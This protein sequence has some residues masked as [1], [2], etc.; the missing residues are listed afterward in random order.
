[1][2]RA[3][4]LGLALVVAC[5]REK[6]P[7]PVAGAATRVDEDE[8]GS[9]T[10][11]V[12]GATIAS[13]T[14]EALFE[15]SAA[16]VID[17]DPG[18]YWLNP[19]RDFPQSIVIAL[20]ARARIDRV[21][22]RTA[23]SSYTANRVQFD[24]S[25]D[26]TTWQALTTATA[27][28]TADAQW[29]DVAP[30]EAEFLRVTV[31]DPRPSQ[32]D[33]RLQSVLARGAELEPPR[34][35]PIEGCWTLNGRAA[36][37]AQ[38]GAHVV[39]ALAIGNLPLFLDGG[40]DGRVVRFVWI[41]GNDYGLAL[42]SVSP[43]GKHLTAVEWHEEAIPLFRAE[44]WFGERC[45]RRAEARPTLREDVAL[46]LLQRVGRYSAFGLRFRD[47]DTLDIEASRE[48]LKLLAQLLESHRARIVVHEFREATP[49]ANKV[50]AQR[51]LES[52]RAALGSDVELVAVGSDAPRQQPVTEAQRAMYSSVDL[53]I[54]R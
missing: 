3:L 50:R 4:F 8:R 22:L 13:R 2:R 20:P 41:R 43:D 6:A 19:P 16:E 37:F 34:P 7:A 36:R 32:T 26:G 52:V 44:S 35:G 38:R 28:E 18:T 1:M 29:F 21:G 9:L 30:I 53:E 17:G 47:D 31:I 51:V 11:I 33:V 5:Q 46:A 49:Q 12:R 54:R 27:R 23:A 42:A 48:T 24:A 45:E 25:G 39:G 40:S 15:T 10:G 14:G